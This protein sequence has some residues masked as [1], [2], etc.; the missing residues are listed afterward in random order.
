MSTGD[1]ADDL[2]AAALRWRLYAAL[3]DAALLREPA[4]APLRSVSGRRRSA[5]AVVAG[6]RT[7]RGVREVPGLA[8]RLAAALG[9]A[10]PDRD[11]PQARAVAA[12]RQRPGA[13]RAAHRAI[14]AR[15]EAPGAP[16]CPPGL[17]ARLFA[18]ATLNVSPDV[19]RVIATQARVGTL[20][21]YLPS[22][23]RD[24]WGDLQTLGERLR[25]QAS[26]PFA[27]DAENPLLQA[28]GAAGRD[29]MRRA[30]RLRSGASGRARSR[31]YA[32]PGEGGG[33]LHGSLLRAAAV[34]PVS[35]TCC[36]AAR[37]PPRSAHALPAL[38]RD[39]PSLQVHA[40]H[41]R[42]REVQVLHDQLR[43]LFED[44][45]FDPPL[46]PRDIAV[47]A[48]DIDPYAPYLDAVFGGRRPRATPFPTRW[49]TP[50]RWPANRWPRC[51]C[52]CSRCRCRASA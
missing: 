52:A 34:G 7:G 19:L 40:C 18:F 16:R 37:R 21:F 12:R 23:S 47:L 10:A 38:R 45:R 22:P 27:G 33:A 1:A 35:A 17:P 11:D 50:A 28:W 31:G 42:L 51:S 46:Q 48:P 8:P 15:F 29:F 13:P 49:P 4:L 5:E 2:D 43:A 39:D 3:A 25:A 14:P 9:S 30:R 44:P 26:D 41:T 24:Y 6:R 32:D 20:H 36:T